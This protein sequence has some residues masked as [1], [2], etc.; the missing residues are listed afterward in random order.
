MNKRSLIVDDNHL[1]G[2]LV[3]V[4]LT[5]LGWQPELVGSG[6]EA[7]ERLAR[8][9]VDL[10]LLDLRMPGLPGEQV[11]RT[12]RDELKLHQ[13][14]VVAF[15]A[16][17]MPEEKARII[18]GGFDGVL[19]KPISFDDVCRLCNDLAHARVAA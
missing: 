12:I 16:H 9:P 10:V 17:S 3:S 18:A 13:L 4:F 6:Q 19:I 8:D 14:P 15:T 7:L 11:C 1:T 2:R 5:R